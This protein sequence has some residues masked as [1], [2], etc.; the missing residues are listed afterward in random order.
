MVIVVPG[1]FPNGPSENFAGQYEEIRAGKISE[2][3]GSAFLLC[4][5]SK[6]HKLEEGG[7]FHKRLH[8][9]KENPSS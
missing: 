8:F 1:S 4:Q 9:D 7:E 5:A 6:G 3:L 2:L